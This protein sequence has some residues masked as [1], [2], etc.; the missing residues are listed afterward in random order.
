MIKSDSYHHLEFGDNS[1]LNV[2][3]NFPFL[4]STWNSLCRYI[5]L[6]VTL[7]FWHD[8]NI[9]CHHVIVLKL[10]NWLWTCIFACVCTDGQCSKIRW[11]F[12][13]LKYCCHS[14]FTNCGSGNE[15]RNGGNQILLWHFLG[16]I[17]LFYFAANVAVW[18]FILTG[19][20]NLLLLDFVK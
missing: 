15:L 12:G 16:L 17:A 4:A 3:V 9:N 7:D 5:C 10:Y 11:Y 19:K 2:N 8:R 14:Y 20:Q 13:A 18:L 6:K 1:Y